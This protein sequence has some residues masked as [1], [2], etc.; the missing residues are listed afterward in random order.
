[1]QQVT[2]KNWYISIDAPPCGAMVY[3][4]QSGILEIHEHD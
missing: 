3:G 1:M 4:L 2:A